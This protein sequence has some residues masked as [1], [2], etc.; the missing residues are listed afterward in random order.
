[1]SAVR[2]ENINE[3]ILTYSIFWHSC[4]PKQE[5][6]NICHIDDHEQVMPEIKYQSTVQDD[7]NVSVGDIEFLNATNNE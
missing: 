6:L 5:R 2:H 1:M 4:K 3:N 7:G